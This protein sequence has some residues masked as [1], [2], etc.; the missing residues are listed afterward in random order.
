MKLLRFASISLI[1]APALMPRLI[2]QE[3][4][5]Q[6]AADLFEKGQREAGDRAMQVQDI[7]AAAKLEPKNKKYQDTCN[8]YRSGLLQDDTAEM[9]IAIS[10]YKNHDLN[11]AETQGVT[12]SQS[13]HRH[14]RSLTRMSK[15]P[16]VC[17]STM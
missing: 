4:P 15:H 6:E 3:R 1:L 7:C 16:P 8:S 14:K 13:F 9:A 2:A 10:A 5:K 11:S 17:T 12:Y